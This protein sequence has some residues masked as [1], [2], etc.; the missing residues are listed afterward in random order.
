MAP[1]GEIKE[2]NIPN[3]PDKKIARGFAFVEM[4]NKNDCLRA[5]KKL[6]GINFKGRTIVLDMAVSK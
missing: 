6:N 4:A 2:I 1:F 5:I 3:H